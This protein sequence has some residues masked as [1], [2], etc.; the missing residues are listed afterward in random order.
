MSYASARWAASPATIWCPRP[1]EA[2]MAPQVLLCPTCHR[3][4]HAL[5]SEAT[6]E[7]D[8]ST[9]EALKQHPQVASFLSWMRK[10]K[11]PASFRVRRAKG[12]I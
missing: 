6:L 10:Q 1:A 2:S 4:L 7:K 8:L 9:V 3:Q 11:G 12:R 5:F